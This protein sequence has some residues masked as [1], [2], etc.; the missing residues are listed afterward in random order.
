MLSLSE[1]T[2]RGVAVAMAAVLALCL[3]ATVAAPGTAE[4]ASVRLSK[5]SVTLMPKKAVTLKL[6]GA[7]ASLVKWRSSKR[8]VAAVSS[9]G[10]VRA[11]RTGSAVV[12]ATYRGKSYR[13]KVTVKR[14]RLR[15]EVDQ[16]L[17]LL[18]D[19]DRS[20]AEVRCSFH[21]DGCSGVKWSSSNGRVAG[22]S[23]RGVVTAKARGT[24]T[25]T[26]KIHGRSVSKK[27]TVR[28]PSIG[29]ECDP[30]YY[31][32][33][34][35]ADEDDDGPFHYVVAT[36]PMDDDWCEGVV[37][38]SSDPAVASVDRQGFLTLRSEGKTVLSVRAHGL[39]ASREVTVRRPA[40]SLE[41]APTMV[42]GQSEQ[43]NAWCS[44]C[45]GLC[46]DLVFSSSDTR[47][48]VVAA[49]GELLTKSAGRTVITV[50]AHGA[51]FSAELEVVPPRLELSQERMVVSLRDLDRCSF[52]LAALCDLNH[53][54]KCRHGIWS[55]SN[56]SVVTVDEY[57]WLGPRTVGE[58][59]V[60]YTAHGVTATCH[61]EVVE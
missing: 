60:T 59:D 22:V 10:R 29:I 23:A 53:G 56:D 34:P 40:V 50:R 9:G 58:A 38:G 54:A 33:V 8:A 51:S 6:K 41:L 61:V 43:L 30:V 1:R 57:G 20:Y 4:A 12:T 17:Y 47:V 37:F 49:F 42:L 27:V 36:C 25:I 7:R 46:D 5:S 28:K 32:G 21:P 14:P 2:G 18:Q 31:L 55:S 16:R 39:T 26:A 24:A 52:S 19:Y 3:A 13:C 35:K 15:L 11:G 48:A 44:H 45:G